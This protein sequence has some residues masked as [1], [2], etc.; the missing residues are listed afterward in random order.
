MGIQ[1]FSNMALKHLAFIHDFAIVSH[2][3]DFGSY[4]NCL[5]ILVDIPMFAANPMFAHDRSHIF[6]D[7]LKSLCKRFL[8]RTSI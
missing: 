8:T 6:F 5:I 3:R 4:L 7:M 2:L 1:V